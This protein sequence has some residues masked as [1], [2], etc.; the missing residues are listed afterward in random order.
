MNIK[1]N[2]KDYGLTHW[3]RVTICAS[4]NRAII[5]PDN[6][7]S[8]DWRRAI[9]WTNDGILLIGPLGTNFSE[10][11]IKSQAFSFKKMHLK[12]S[13]GKWQP[14]CLGLVV[15]CVSNNNNCSNIS[16]NV[17][18]D[19]NSLIPARSGWCFI[20]GIFKLVLPTVIFRSYD[21]AFR[22]WNNAG[23]GNGLV[24]SGNKPT[25]EPMFPQLCVAIWHRQSIMS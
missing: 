25:P 9:I 24:P 8:P 12:M 13:P 14:S 22:W 4:V 11:I 10:I 3:G 5:G 7:L 2:L 16:L 17:S 1:R 20:N 6:G 23:S 15:L 19:I 21:N 18:L